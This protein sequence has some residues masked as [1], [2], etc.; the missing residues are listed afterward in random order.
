MV[1]G[2]CT[3]EV[4]RLAVPET[5]V[6]RVRSHRFPKFLRES[7]LYPLLVLGPIKGIGHVHANGRVVDV[8]GVASVPYRRVHYTYK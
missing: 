8:V 5:A 3:G 6:S 7:I 2:L 1:Y 4:R